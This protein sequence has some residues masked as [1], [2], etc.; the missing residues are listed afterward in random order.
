LE[1]NENNKKFEH[2]LL[3]MPFNQKSKEV[4]K[5]DNY[6]YSQIVVFPIETMEKNK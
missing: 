3:P 4:K 6:N 5:R 1:L 2:L